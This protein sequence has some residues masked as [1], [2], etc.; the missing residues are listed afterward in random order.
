[1][2]QAVEDQGLRQ[3]RAKVIEKLLAL[4][5]RTRRISGKAV[6]VARKRR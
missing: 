6:Q 2:R 5:K 4:G 1:M 3:R